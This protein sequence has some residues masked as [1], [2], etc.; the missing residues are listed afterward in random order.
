MQ[1]KLF[2]GPMFSGKTRRF[3]IELEKYV[4]AK[5]HVILLEP[6]CDTR[7]GSHGNYIAQR[8]EELKITEYVHYFKIEHVDDII[9][10]TGKTLMKAKIEAIFIDEYHMLDFKRQFF[11]DYHNSP[12]KDIPLIFSGLIS[13][14]DAVVLNAAREII[15]FMD[16]I[17][18][19]NAICMDCGNTA[20]YYAYIG[21]W[22]MNKRIDTGQNYKCLCHD[23]YMKL[24]KKPIIYKKGVYNVNS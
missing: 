1:T 11:Y 8:L 22:K 7:G 24:T 16:K 3:V 13:G 14:A 2:T 15:P 9:K 12:L 19:E 5:R 21:T 6:V 10:L 17:E 4:I 20:N 18:K 23:C